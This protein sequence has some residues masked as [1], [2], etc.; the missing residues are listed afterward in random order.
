MA[1]LIEQTSK[2]LNE[3]LRYTE[4]LKA[5]KVPMGSSLYPDMEKLWKKYHVVMNQ[6]STGLAKFN[7]G[8]I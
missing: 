4:R 7:R 3:A 5:K 1:T 2:E 6:G 8:E